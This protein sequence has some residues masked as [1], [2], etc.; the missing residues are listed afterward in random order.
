MNVAPN[1]PR[2]DDVY[3]YVRYFTEPRPAYDD[4]LYKI[5]QG[6][7]GCYLNNGHIYTLTRGILLGHHTGIDINRLVQCAIDNT[8]DTVVQIY[9]RKMSMLG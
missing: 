4:A 1:T 2:G 5:E 7:L 8:N 3:T 9:S 6:W